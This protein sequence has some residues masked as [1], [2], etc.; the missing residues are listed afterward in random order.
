MSLYALKL[1]GDVQLRRGSDDD[2]ALPRKAK[3]LLA[4]LALNSQTPQPRDK[5]AGLLWPDRAEEQARHS[6]RQCLFTLS[7]CAKE[8]ESP[9]VHADRQLVAL[10]EKTVEVDV[11]EF[12]RLVTLGTHEALR[13][14]VLHYAGDFLADLSIEDEPLEAWCAAE[15]TRLRDACYEALANLTSYYAD[16]A[17]LDGAIETCQQL[18]RLD[19]LREDG[20]RT[21]MR[22]YRRAG[23]RAEAIKQYRHCVEVLRRELNV[24]PEDATIQLYR[25]IR[26][27]S[28]VEP[29]PEGSATEALHDPDGRGRGAM[30]RRHGP[31]IRAASLGVMAGLL[32]VL[33]WFVV[34]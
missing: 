19:P 5:L 30:L 3:L 29:R 33:L 22:L 23:R 7:K 16:V 32:A 24:A 25:E 6:L 2:L 1:F 34:R 13:Q 9:P 26:G 11:R 21:L 20:H 15:R 31:K 17:N 4:Y 28:E 10:D 14:A 27:R 8:G 18:T 12:E